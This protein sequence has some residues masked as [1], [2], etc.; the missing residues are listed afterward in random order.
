MWRVS[1]DIW[2]AARNVKASAVTGA[3]KRSY[4][5]MRVMRVKDEPFLKRKMEA[6]GLEPMTSRV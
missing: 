4:V 6:L 5:D 3:R 2:L 1:T